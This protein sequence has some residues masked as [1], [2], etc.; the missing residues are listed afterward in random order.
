MMQVKS[1]G[2]CL[3]L[4][5]ALV[6][7]ADTGD[8]AARRSVEIAASND[9]LREAAFLITSPEDRS[10]PQKGWVPSSA[11]KMLLDTGNKL[12]ATLR[13]AIFHE[14]IY[15]WGLS[16]S[17]PAGTA[18]ELL[19]NVW[20]GDIRFQ[21]AEGTMSRF[22]HQWRSVKATQTLPDGESLH[23]RGTLLFEGVAS[24]HDIGANEQD[25]IPLLAAMKRW[26]PFHLV[27]AVKRTETRFDFGELQRAGSVILGG[28]SST[29]PNWSPH[30]KWVA[31][32]LAW[33]AVQQAFREIV[34][35][36]SVVLHGVQTFPHAQQERIQLNCLLA[37]DF[38]FDL[39]RGAITIGTPARARFVSV[40]AVR[41]KQS[42][43]QR[44]LRVEAAVPGDLEPRSHNQ[45]TSN[46][47]AYRTGHREPIKSGRGR[48]SFPMAELCAI[49][50]E[51]LD[52]RLMPAKREA[53]RLLNE[54]QRR[55]PERPAPAH[56]MVTD[57]VT[58]I[59]AA[60]A[61][62]ASPLNTRKTRK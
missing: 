21:I 54:F 39:V 37:A 30:P 24:L 59:Y 52:Q 58:R 6:S 62:S 1:S 47:K 15:L 8:L 25:G 5:E 13:A 23:A 35:R 2:P 45:T 29:Q 10:E 38:H 43:S 55:Y 28:G 34:E 9:I 53:D 16:H 36:G 32:R 50:A 7:S 20:A 49:V 18:A 11:R 31:I 60:A 57:H 33:E 27:D 61:A 19:P 17:A 26:S 46:R 12:V 41:P 42:F 44:P 3:T 56:R 22:G 4:L 14:R 40:V 48:P 51:R